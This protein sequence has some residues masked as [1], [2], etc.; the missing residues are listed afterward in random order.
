MNKHHVISLDEQ[1]RSIIRDND[2]G[3]YTVPTAGLYP[4]QWNWDSVFA[5]WG[6]AEF[7]IDRAWVEIETLFSGQWPNGMV[8]HILFHK[9]DPGYFPNAEVWGAIGNGPVPSSGISQPPIAATF[10]RAIWRSNREAGNTR[11][12]DLFPK[13]KAWHKWFLDWRTTQEGA[14]YITHPW[15]AGRDNSADWDIGMSGITPEGV[16][17]YTRRDTGHVDASMRPTKEEYDRY[18]W[19]V[20]RGSAAR[21]NEATLMQDRPFAVADPTLTLILLRANRDLADIAEELGEDRS[22]IDEWSKRLEAGAI[23]LRM[24]KT[25]IFSAKDLPTGQ[26][27]GH[28]TSASFLC[29]YAGI[30][31]MQMYDQL[32]KSMASCT[33]P[34]PSLDI[35]AEG[36]DG[37]RYWR[38]PTWAIM[39]AIIG[40]GLQDMGYEKEAEN[41]LLGTRDLIAKNGFAE[42]HNPLTG[43]PAGGQA[44]TWTAAVW[45]AWASPNA[46]EK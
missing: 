42:Y 38:G 37:M 23:S 39:N 6:F 28:L 30:D 43:A 35:N 9:E 20:N 3:G 40:I 24:E 41:M 44:F 29:W 26:F 2:R 33:Y 1:A 17:T 21:W 45:L 13:I 10:I 14:V 34:I 11:V 7:D 31:D 18:I 22:E 27:T 36:F 8:P 15:E 19:L 12:S 16:G 25:G 46:G 4:Y 32:K 5:A